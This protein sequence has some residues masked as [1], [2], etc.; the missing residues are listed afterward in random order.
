[1]ASQPPPTMPLMKFLVVTTASDC[2]LGRSDVV[3]LEVDVAVVAEAAT[4]GSVASMSSFVLQVMTH[5]EESVGNWWRLDAGPTNF[6]S[7]DLQLGFQ[8]II[9]L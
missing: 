2:S 3:L 7:F 6:F 8:P 5:R 1:M 4:A 9:F